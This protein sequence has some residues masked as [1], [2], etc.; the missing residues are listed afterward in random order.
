MIKLLDNHMRETL[1]RLKSGLL[2]DSNLKPYRED[3]LLTVLEYFEKN[4]MYEECLIVRE[5][6]KNRFNHELESAFRKY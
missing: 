6:I 4:E 1:E 5:I 2:F 3:F